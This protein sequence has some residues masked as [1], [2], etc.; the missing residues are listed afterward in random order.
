ML[1]MK[2]CACLKRMT[3]VFV[4]EKAFHPFNDDVIISF[5][6]HRLLAAITNEQRERAKRENF[7]AVLRSPEEEQHNAKNPHG[8]RHRC[9]RQKL[10][11]SHQLCKFLCMK[12]HFIE[13]K[14]HTGAHSIHIWL[15]TSTTTPKTTKMWK[16]ARP[17]FRT[18]SIRI[19][20][21]WR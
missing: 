18:P 11:V 15:N 17:A 3:N 1:Q 6:I 21:C 7:M 5:S 12:T 8:N 13:Y 10:F 2:F 9:Y 14:I 20:P 4:F 19:Q 16:K